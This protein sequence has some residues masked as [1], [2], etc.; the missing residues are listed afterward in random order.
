VALFLP[1]ILKGFI[2]ASGPFG[3]A[4]HLLVS[5]FTY[6]VYG[7]ATWTYASALWGIR[8]LGKQALTLAPFHEDNMMGTQP[9]GSLCL[10]ISLSLFGAIGI[11]TVITLI[12]PVYLQFTSILFAL[13]ALGFLLFFLTLNSVHTQLAREKKAQKY[14][15][16]AHSFEAIEFLSGTRE[17]KRR[18]VSTELRELLLDL[19]AF[20]AMET[21]RHRLREIS[22]WPFETKLIGKLSAIAL[23]LI[24]AIVSNII[25]KRLLNL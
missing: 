6:C 5:L 16:Y 24:V 20:A 25:I 19:K 9:F 3:R 18:A 22:T 8:T 2:E 13:T 1:D 10:S 17:D 14:T 11:M 23:S 12:S 7:T 21:A 4:F 15:L